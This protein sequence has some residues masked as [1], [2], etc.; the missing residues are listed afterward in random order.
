MTKRTMNKFIIFM[1]YGVFV[2][3]LI[4][5]CTG[6]NNNRDI[7]NSIQPNSVKMYDGLRSR[8]WKM[9]ER[10]ISIGDQY[11]GRKGFNSIR[12]DKGAVVSVENDA[13]HMWISE[14]YQGKDFVVKYDKQDHK[15]KLY[16]LNDDQFRFTITCCD[17][18]LVV[19]Q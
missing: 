4:S 11:S 10:W 6:E 17:D 8:T 1:I 19:V 18:G 14:V 7:Q 5:G 9:G 12:I 15:I 13:G 3:S 16:D 2:I